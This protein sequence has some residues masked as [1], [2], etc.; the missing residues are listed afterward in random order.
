MD[1]SSPGQFSLNGV[2]VRVDAA[3]FPTLQISAGDRLQVE[4]KRIDGQYWLARFES[5]PP[6]R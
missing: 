4:V 5:R 6:R 1:G 2:L 3:L